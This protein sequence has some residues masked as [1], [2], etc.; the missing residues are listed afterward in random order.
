M[1][2]W[3]RWQEKKC[4]FHE[5]CL[6]EGFWVWFWFVCWWFF[7]QKFI[8]IYFTLTFGTGVLS[9]FFKRH[10]STF[11]FK[12]FFF[13]FSGGWECL[14]FMC[15]SKIQSIKLLNLLKILSFVCLLAFLF[16]FI[17]PPFFFEVGRLVAL[18]PKALSNTS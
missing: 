16:L 8:K 3:C 1:M 5:N 2:P 12:I 18:E 4:L 7:S 15:C 13:F 17:P 6:I 9:I 10:L 11:T 14:V